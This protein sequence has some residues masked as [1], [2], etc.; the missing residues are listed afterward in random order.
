MFVAAVRHV[1]SRAPA[2]WL[3]DEKGGMPYRRGNV[4]ASVLRRASEALAERVVRHRP[5]WILSMAQ[6]SADIPGAMSIGDAS[7]F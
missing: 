7:H 1:W 2:K 4:A 3:A 5:S 6:R